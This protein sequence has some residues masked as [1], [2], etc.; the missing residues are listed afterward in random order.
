MNELLAAA[1]LLAPLPPAPEPAVVVLWPGGAPGAVG[2]ED[3]DRPSLAVHRAPADKATGAAVVVCPGGGYGRLALDHEGR[4]VAAWL[5]GHG[6]TAAVLTY[7]L[8]PRYRHPAPL[9]DAQRALRWV[10]AHAAE[11]GVRADAVGVW[12]FSA[13]GHLAA[14]AATKFDD[15]DPDAVDPLER[16]GSRPDFLVLAYPVISFAEEYAHQG[17][18]NNLLGDGADR[19]LVEGLSAERHVTPRT[20]PAFIFYT[21][22]DPV[23]PE[24]GVAFYLAL[25]RAKVPAEL[26]IYERGRHGLGLAQGDPVVSTWTERLRDWLR[27]RGAVRP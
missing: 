10:R 26:H 3:A 16:P 19:A 23:R 7:R 21:D 6:I 5:N 17:S 27:L 25:R 13:G 24:N 15:G 9:Q 4:Q 1:L 14:T 20:P 22:E 11:L 18:R 8:G 12:G 2:A